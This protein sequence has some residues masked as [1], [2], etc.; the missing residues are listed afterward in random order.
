MSRVRRFFY[1]MARGS[2]ILHIL[3][4]E[5]RVEGELTQCGRRVQV[6]WRWYSRA[7]SNDRLRDHPRCKQCECAS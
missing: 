3:I 6:G 5:K 4:G 2:R 1:A 7:R